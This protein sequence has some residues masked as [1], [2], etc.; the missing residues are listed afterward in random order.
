MSRLI[1]TLPYVTRLKNGYLNI[2]LPKN[3]EKL[4][5]LKP[6]CVICGHYLLTAQPIYYCGRC[7]KIW[8]I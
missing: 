3:Q 2:E 7:D 5:N 4:S 1:R 6:I 8:L